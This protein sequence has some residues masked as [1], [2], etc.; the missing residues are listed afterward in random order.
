[1]TRVMK[2]APLRKPQKKVNSKDEWQEQQEEDE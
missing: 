2:R 1:M